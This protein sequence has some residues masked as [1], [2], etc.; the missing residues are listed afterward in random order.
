M[1]VSSTNKI[2]GSEITFQRSRI[3]GLVPGLLK[4]SIY[5]ILLQYLLKNNTK[6]PGEWGQL[7]IKEI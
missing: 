6:F 5:L 7:T 1:F 4:A 2:P 3:S